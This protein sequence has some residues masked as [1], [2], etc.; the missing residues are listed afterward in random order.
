[1]KNHVHTLVSRHLFVCLFVCFVREFVCEARP[2]R[3][4][5]ESFLINVSVQVFEKHFCRKRSESQ[6]SPQLKRGHAQF[7]PQLWPSL[8]LFLRTKINLRP[9][10]SNETFLQEE[11][12]CHEKFRSEGNQLITALPQFCRWGKTGVL[13]CCVLLLS[14]PPS[15][16]YTQKRCNNF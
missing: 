16:I 4:L 6:L 2:K 5:L 13:V 8:V 9:N 1:M 12:V 3:Y 10:K 14:L 15:K 7:S 11:L